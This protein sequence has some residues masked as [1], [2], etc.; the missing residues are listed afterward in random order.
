[1]RRVVTGDMAGA[2]AAG[3]RTL[4]FLRMRLQMI[5]IRA[6]AARQTAEKNMVGRLLEV[7]SGSEKVLVGITGLRRRPQ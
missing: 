2:I 3:R 5:A 1:M 7:V 4:Q 6:R